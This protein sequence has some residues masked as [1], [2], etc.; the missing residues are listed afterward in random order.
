MEHQ[1]FNPHDPFY[2]RKCAK[3]GG[4][5]VVWFIDNSRDLKGLRGRVAEKMVIF[6]AG[7]IHSWKCLGHKPSRF[8]RPSSFSHSL[9]VSLCLSLCLSLSLYLSL[10]LL[11][12]PNVT[13]WKVL[14]LIIQPG[15]A[16]EKNPFGII[17]CC[18]CRLSFP[19][20]TL[21]E[22]IEWRAAQTSLS[23]SSNLIGV[24]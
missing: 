14:T 19:T 15:K 13:L 4:P 18:K 22:A 12:T 1:G 16:L 21:R 6:Y 23:E 17:I 8:S 5:S 24:S 2:Q 20:H 7:N 9:S 11:F 3:S 10:S